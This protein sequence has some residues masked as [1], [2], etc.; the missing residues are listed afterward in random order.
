MKRI[1]ATLFGVL[2]LSG[3]A[4]AKTPPEVIEP[5]KAYLAAVQKDDKKVAASMAYQAW[6]A[7]ESLMG[8]SRTTGDLASNYALL[9][10]SKY[11]NK[12]ATKEISEAF[13]RSIDLAALH[14]D[15]AS[16]IELQRRVDYLN[17]IA[18]K[19]YN[20]GKSYGLDDL[21]ERIALLGF[22]RSSFE[23]ESEGLKA[24]DYWIKQKPK[25]VI[26]YGERSLLI[27]DEADDNL[28]SV[29]RYLVPVY[30]AKA[31]EEKKDPIKAAL[32]YQKLITDLDKFNA[33]D[34][35]VS[36]TAYGEW[37]RLRDEI[38]EDESD[39]PRVASIKGFKVPAGRTAE[40]EPLIR[41]PPV[42]PS[43]FTQGINSGAVEFVFDI[44][45]EGYVDNA[46]IVASTDTRL[47]EASR[48]SLK[49]WRYTP[50][51]PED[52]RKGLKT[53]IRFDLASASGRILPQGE[54]RAR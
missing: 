4:Q 11:K 13:K 21:S 53:K 41:M 40:L 26:E 37:L 42:F 29:I 16:E 36:G 6:K 51:I 12:P 46:V 44:D 34:N 43:S 18:S 17:W 47:H 19:D 39:D 52:E 23:G 54:M 32:T 27:F 15:N 24:Q 38:L 10:P 50:N 7:A 35:T 22:K 25:K 48:E 9:N 2:A 1:F 14:T 33:H 20:P 8:D 30:L 31:Y 3:V 28:V 45:A 49:L 5:Y